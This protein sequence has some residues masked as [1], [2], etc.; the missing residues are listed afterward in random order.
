MSIQE[1]WNR[2][3]WEPFAEVLYAPDVEIHTIN[4]PQPPRIG[5]AA[6]HDLVSMLREAYPDLEIT[7][8]RMVREGPL[9]ACQLAVSGTQRGPF[10]GFPPSGKRMKVSEF[11]IWG[12][13]NGDGRLTRLWIAPD[14]SGQLRQLG[15]IPSG[16]PPKPV[17]LLMRLVQRLKAGPPA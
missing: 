10:R 7:P 9:V 2:G 14:V 4:L 11:G 8:E 6:F 1:V 17:M 12:F 3:L 13:E 5:R 16:P 15:H